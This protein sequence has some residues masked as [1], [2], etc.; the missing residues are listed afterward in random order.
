MPLPPDFDFPRPVP[1]TRRLPASG[2][3]QLI[4]Q[5]SGHANLPVALAYGKHAVAGNLILQQVADDGD[6]ILFIAFGAGEWSSPEAFW[7]NGLNFD[8][9][10]TS[11]YHFHPGRDGQLGIETD[12]SIRNQHFC[13]F[14]P[15]G[16]H[17][18]L[19]FSRTAYVALKLAPDDTAP[20][21]GYSVKSIWK[22]R[23]VRSFDASG[24][25]ADYE[26][27]PNPATILLDL[28]ITGH[29]A[30][31][32]RNVPNEEIETAA[33]SGA[34]RATNVVTIKTR[35][36][37]PFQ[38]GQT[39]R[40]NR[41]TDPSFNGLFTIASVPAADTFTYNQIGSDATSGDGDAILDDLTSEEKARID[42]A[43]F[44]SWRVDCNT[45]GLECHVAF[46]Q[47][48]DLLRAI[49]LV[50]ICGR[51]YLLLKNGKFSP[52]MDKNR[53]SV[54]TFGADHFSER[55]LQLSRKVGRNLAN[56]LI[57]RFRDLESGRGPGTLSTVG[58]AV[59]GSGT[60]FTQWFR[61]DS[62]LRMLN[63]EGYSALAAVASDTSMTLEAAFPADVTDESYENPAL[64]FQGSQIRLDEETQQSA[65]GR[66]IS[67]EMD[68]G[69]S[70]PARVANLLSYLLR[71]T[72]L[73][74]NASGLLLP[75]NGALDLLPG[76][77]VTLP[78]TQE[79]DPFKTR[80]FEILEATDEPNGARS[81]ACQEF[82]ASIFDP[83]DAPVS[84][85][86]PSVPAS[87]GPL[88]SVVPT[89][90]FGGN[91]PQMA[92]RHWALL[93]P[94]NANF[95]TTWGPAFGSMSAY[96]SSSGLDAADGFWWYVRTSV[97]TA[98][99]FAGF[100]SITSTSLHPIPDLHP[101]WTVKMRPELYSNQR[102]WIAITS[103]SGVAVGNQATSDTPDLDYA[104]FRAS[105]GA[106]D[107]NWQCMTR[108]AG[109]ATTQVNSGVAVDTTRMHTFVI[110]L[111]PSIARF[112]IDEV[113]VATIET[114]LPPAGTALD[115]H[116]SHTNLLTPQL[117]TNRF[118]FAAWDQEHTAG[119]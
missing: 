111:T 54:G 1:P 97:N 105:T 8:V 20:S 102:I 71:R 9:G 4:E 106:G 95:V 2:Q 24:N 93:V 86:V 11:R 77:I 83:G 7:V 87:S 57:G 17:P 74:R 32:K 114:N 36:A 119:A 116:Y 51:G 5:L 62:I 90:V 92:K 73:T 109:V 84:P 64:N 59:T 66:V 42:F 91:S 53:S 15:A 25:L 45:E 3:T 76:D 16:F 68:F 31:R 65:L 55:R 12:A 78:D 94:S 44:N 60:L 38:V 56:Q 89:P 35:Q 113:L 98:G 80:E 115:Y 107:N 43:A 28:L 49:E 13:S 112:Y 117:V 67:A 81:V 108:R 75:G 46:V 34:V 72:F 100:S 41:V 47:Q 39:I 40:I 96:S 52:A 110:E 82:D 50:L 101:R 103:R 99:T 88:I 70:T 26:W 18:N 30:P 104:G 118:N 37:H 27:S 10:N 22:A 19:T 33:N 21:D 48:T 79:F 85:L 61:K 58:T 29:I 69:N 63:V 14:W 23:K 6:T